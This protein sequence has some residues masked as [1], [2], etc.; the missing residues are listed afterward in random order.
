MQLKQQEKGLFLFAYLSQQ[1][2]WFFCVLLRQNLAN[3]VVWFVLEHKFKKNAL[4]K[5]ALLLYLA[6]L[7]HTSAY[8]AIAAIIALWV[9]RKLPARKIVPGS[10]LI[11]V[12][13]FFCWKKADIVYS[14]LH[15]KLCRHTL[16]YVS[17]CSRGI[18]KCHKLCSE[19]VLCGVTLSRI[20]SEQGRWF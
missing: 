18:I 1:M 9:I 2:I 7:L 12:T 11:G 16:Q 5:K 15:G 13:V 10:L 8:I 6:T 14:L 4:I 17:E 20:H 3:L 19:I